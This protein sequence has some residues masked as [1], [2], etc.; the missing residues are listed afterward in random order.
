MINYKKK[1]I[2]KNIN[3]KK[4]VMQEQYLYFTS[5]ELYKKIFSEKI[6]SIISIYDRL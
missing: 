1:K 4:H 5:F 6:V 2:D 3:V